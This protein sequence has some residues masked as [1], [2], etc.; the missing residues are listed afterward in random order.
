MSTVLQ[1]ACKILQNARIFGLARS[2]IS[3]MNQ[4][5]AGLAQLVEHLICNRT[6]IQHFQRLTE[7]ISA[8]YPPVSAPMGPILQNAEGM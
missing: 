7:K 3:V 8:D 5:I 4:R 6:V 1:N 2:E